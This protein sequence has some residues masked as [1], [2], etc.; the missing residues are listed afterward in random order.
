MRVGAGE[1]PRD[2][3][4]AAG[5][6]MP[7]GNPLH[8]MQDVRAD[9][10]SQQSLYLLSCL[11]NSAPGSSRLWGGECGGVG[12][13]VCESG[14]CDLDHRGM[15]RP[16][17]ESTRSSGLMGCWP[18]REGG[19]GQ[20]AEPSLPAPVPFPTVSLLAAMVSLSPFPIP[21][22]GLGELRLWPLS[23]GLSHT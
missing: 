14:G 5:P 16:P 7:E 18:L 1:A 2:T 15:S 13:V 8:R 23:E 19:A 12:G 21:P 3:G 20:G 11:L 6:Q 10:A 17:E 4:M 9:L 22:M